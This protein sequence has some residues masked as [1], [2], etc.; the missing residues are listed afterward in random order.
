MNWKE[1]IFC[2]MH[3]LLL[4]INEFCI[5]LRSHWKQTF[6]MV[7]NTNL[8][9]W[10]FTR[11]EFSSANC[12]VTGTCFRCVCA[13]IYIHICLYINIYTPPWESS[14]IF[15]LPALKQLELK[16]KAKAIF[17]SSTADSF[18]CPLDFKKQENFPF[19]PFYLYSYQLLVVN[20]EEWHLSYP[21][22]SNT[23]ILTSRQLQQCC[24]N[25]Y[26][27]NCNKVTAF[28]FSMVLHMLVMLST[29]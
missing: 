11:Q 2:L 14:A 24:L 7:S 20:A 3:I 8:Q 25:I 19:P 26:W 23:L 21:D 13:C 6:V 10:F 28:S 18:M 22:S 16:R 5:C 17:V 9:E 27:L 12:P 29:A 1:N 4:K 15:C